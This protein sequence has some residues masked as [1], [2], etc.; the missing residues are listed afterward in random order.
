MHDTTQPAEAAT[1][2]RLTRY[3]WLSIGAAVATI[4]LKTGAFFITGS[5]GLLSDALESLVNL[6]G[7]I[8][9]LS[10]L[11]IAARPPDEDHAYGHGKA[12]YFSSGAEGTLIIVAAVSIAA[13]ALNRLF[14]PAPLDNLDLG[15]VIS[16]A[17]SAV[18]LV[19]ALVI[20]RAGRLHRSITLEANASHLMTDVW[21]SVGVIAGVG[22]VALTD[23]QW[24][25]PVVAI[26]MAANITRTGWLIVRRSILGL[27]DTALPAA[28]RQA[29]EIILNQYRPQG[30]QF[31]ALRTRQAGVRRFISMHVLVPGSWSVQQGHD[32]LEKIE[33]DI[34]AKL[35]ATTIFTHLEP[36]EDPSSWADTSLERSGGTASPKKT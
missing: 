34:R 32:L 5:I 23:W 6:A 24:L 16:A 11:A 35:P 19:V 3:A 13:A 9:A 8:M 27:M 31:H 22:A 1:Q 33:S 17:A 36:V 7:A 20:G 12:E 26:V 15:L 18:N 4:G 29:I 28:D 21:T 10:M 25:D 14:H 30:L 2:V